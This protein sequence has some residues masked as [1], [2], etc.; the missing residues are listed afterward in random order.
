MPRAILIVEPEGESK[1][2]REVA[3]HDE[4][5]LQERLKANPD[6]LPIEDFELAGPLMVVGRDEP[7]FGFG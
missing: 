6:L 1:V 5:Q 7:A 2:L 3:A 4:Q